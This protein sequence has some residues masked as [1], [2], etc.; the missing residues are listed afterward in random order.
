MKASWPSVTPDEAEFYCHKPHREN[1]EPTKLK[2]RPSEPITLLYMLELVLLATEWP[3]SISEAPRKKIPIPDTLVPKK[4]VQLLDQLAGD[5]LGSV[6]VAALEAIG[7][8]ETS[9][10]LEC[11][12]EN[13]ALTVFALHWYTRASLYACCGSS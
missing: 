10:H 11:M 7:D 12:V 1:F 8:A 5:K 13:F 9:K 3:Y 4:L 6:Y 2:L